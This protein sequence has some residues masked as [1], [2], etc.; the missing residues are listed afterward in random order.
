[1]EV[2]LLKDISN[3]GLAGQVKKVTEGYARNFL[4]P[5]KL[6]VVANAADVERFK[7]NIV[8]KEVDVQ[9]AGSRVAIL[10]DQI[11][12]ITLILKKK[13]ND[14]GKLYGAV[15]PEDVLE[16]LAQKHVNV[17]KKQVEF[18]KSI[19]TTGEYEVIIRLTSKLKPALKLKVEGIVE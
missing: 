7:K 2:L 19:R 6:A 3:L 10:A 14:K 11:K 17:E 5:N 18:T 9:V 16:L 8:Q 15:G 13:S 1:M 12:N 4:F